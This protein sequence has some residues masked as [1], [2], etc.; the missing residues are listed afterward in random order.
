MYLLPGE[1]CMFTGDEDWL[2]WKFRLARNHDFPPE[3]KGYVQFVICD[4][5]CPRER[6]PIQCRSFPLAP[7]LD[8]EGNLGVTLDTLTGSLICPLVRSPE[9][10]E[11][12]AKF[13]ES[14]LEAWRI[15]IKDPLI[16][17][18]VFRQSRRL[19]ED[20]EAP[21]RALLK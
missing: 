19:D 10:H 9:K 16:R 21:W 11:L 8:E 17:V 3:W 14:V 18:D 4:A 2:T 20:R 12:S 5:T 7:Y 15:L 13:V 1:E 6:R